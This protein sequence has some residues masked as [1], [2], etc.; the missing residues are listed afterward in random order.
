[1]SFQTKSIHIDIDWST[2]KDMSMVGGLG[3]FGK[4]GNGTEVGTKLNFGNLMSVHKF[5]LEKS[6]Y[7]LGIFIGGISN[8]GS[9]PSGHKSHN[10]QAN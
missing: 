2:S 7:M 9:E 5:I 1:M 8:T 6:K 10:L 4:L 3:M